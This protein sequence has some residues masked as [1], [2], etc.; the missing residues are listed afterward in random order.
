[1]PAKQTLY[2]F[3]INKPIPNNFMAITTERMI[4]KR[5]NSF[6]FLGITLDEA[7]NCSVHVNSLCESL[8]KYLS[9]FSHIKYKVTPKVTRQIYHAF[10]YSRIQYGIDVYS[11]CSETQTNR[12][13]VIQNK[14]LKLILRLERLTATKLLYNEI[15]ALKVTHIGESNVLGF[16]D[17]V[18]CG[19][20]SD[21]FL[22]YYTK[23]G[24]P[25]MYDQRVNL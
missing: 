24:M 21:I 10:I 3:T 7:L 25:M 6:K 11:S 17:K 18:L 13:Q 12:P 15:N 9:I 22:S 19:H 23:K 14:V 4:I 5:V 8:L 1:M 20:C 2:F 16:V